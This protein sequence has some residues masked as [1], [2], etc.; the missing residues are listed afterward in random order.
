[1]FGQDVITDAA[2]SSIKNIRIAPGALIDLQTDPVAGERQAKVERLE[3]RF[4]YAEKFADTI[5][6]IKNDMF[7]TLEVPNVGL[8]QLKGLMQ[9]GKSMKALYWGLMA[10]CEEDWAEWGPALKQMADY[11]FRMVDVYNLYGARSIARYETVLEI[12][13]TYPIPEDEAD[14]KRIDMEEVAAQLRSRKSYMDKW[15]NYEDVDSELEQIQ[16][17]QQALKDD[18]VRAVE[19]ELSD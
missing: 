7:D 14:E 17:E 10:A 8:E 5:N 13:H 12:H 6:R 9:S 15:G 1:M 19:T 4:T 3:S 18:F 2:E 16:L 11:I